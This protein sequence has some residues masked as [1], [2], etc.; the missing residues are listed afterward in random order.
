M[1]KMKPVQPGVG[2]LKLGVNP[3]AGIPFSRHLGAVGDYPAEIIIE[4]YCKSL[5][6]QYANQPCGHMEIIRIEKQTGIRRKP[7][8]RRP[9]I[10]GKNPLAVGLYQ[11][12]LTEITAHSDQAITIGFKIKRKNRVAP[13]IKPIDRFQ[14]ANPIE[15]ALNGTGNRNAPARAKGPG[16]D[17]YNRGR[18]PALVF[19]PFHQGDNPVYQV[20]R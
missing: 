17:L 10:P 13:R 8:Y 6:A 9:V 20:N 7:H 15:V 1:G 5:P 11:H 16:T 3:A 12:P 14:A 2:S 19:R 4:T 18:L